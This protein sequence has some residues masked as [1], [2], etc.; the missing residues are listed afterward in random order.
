MHSGH[1][2]FGKLPN[3][4]VLRSVMRTEPTGVGSGWVGGLPGPVGPTELGFSLPLPLLGEVR[5]GF[6][7]G[8]LSEGAL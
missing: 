1:V 8:C 5:Q 6:L 7:G 4:C 3:S 2:T